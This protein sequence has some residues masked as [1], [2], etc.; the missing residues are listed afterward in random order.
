MSAPT[1]DRFPGLDLA[2]FLAAPPPEPVWE[3]HGY[4]ARGDVVLEVGDP[5]AGKSMNVL[6]RAVTAARGGGEHL[7]EPVAAARVLFIDLENPEDVVY[8]RLYAFGLRD[9]VETLR[10]VWRPAGFDLLKKATVDSLRATIIEHEA[11]I[12]Y[13]DSLRRAAPGLD[14]ND[15]AKVSAVFTPLREL[16]AELGCTVDV[17]HHPRKPIG[18][19][20]VEALYA[21]RGSGDLIGSVDSYLFYRR[22]GSGLVRIEHGKARR[23]GEHDPVHF[24]IEADDDGR[25]SIHPVQIEHKTHNRDRVR[26]WR[27]ANPA[28]LQASA[29][30]E[31]GIS[32]ETV[33]RYWKAAEAAQETL[34]MD[35]D[36]A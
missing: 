1:P 7:G 12:V 13:I 32:V 23:G 22:L 11:E 19:A 9:N 26:E 15:S 3:Y 29:A 33:K 8:A 14:E 10:Y 36:E 18:D 31:L 20:K 28:G 16:A 2:A 5:G 17:V 4:T 25:P 34:N 24:R 27:A 6:A 30:L 35:G 21:A